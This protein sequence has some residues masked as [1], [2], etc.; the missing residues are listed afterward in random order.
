LP[1][2]LAQRRLES[3]LPTWKCTECRSLLGVSNRE[4][5]EIRI[6]Y[7]DLD[8]TSREDCVI[9]RCRSCGKENVVGRRE[10]KKNAFQPTIGR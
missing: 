8:L 10:V 3:S 9:I 2:G 5:T 6:K 4:K 7:K 1:E